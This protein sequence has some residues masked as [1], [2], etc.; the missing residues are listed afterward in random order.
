MLTIS[1]GASNATRDHTPSSSSSKTH[2]P[3]PRLSRR[4]RLLVVSVGSG[5]KVMQV[6]IAQPYDKQVGWNTTVYN[7]RVNKSLKEMHAMSDSNGYVVLSPADGSVS[8]ERTTPDIYSRHASMTS[9]ASR[10]KYLADPASFSKA[11]DIV[12][13]VQLLSA[14]NSLN[15]DVTVICGNL[16][17]SSKSVVFPQNPP[18]LQQAC[19]FCI[20][21]GEKR[22]PDPDLMK[23]PVKSRDDFHFFSSFK[24][25]S[26]DNLRAGVTYSDLKMPDGAADSALLEAARRQGQ[27]DAPRL[28]AR[29]HEVPKGWS[30]R[31][32]AKYGDMFPP[33]IMSK[34]ADTPGYYIMAK[35]ICR[36]LR[37]TLQ[38][39][40]PLQA[41]AQRRGE[42][43]RHAAPHE[44][45]PLDGRGVPCRSGRCA[46]L[47]PRRAW[48]TRDRK[49]RL[50]TLAI[51]ARDQDGPRDGR[52]ASCDRSTRRASS[53]RVSCVRSIARR[54]SSTQ[55]R[56]GGGVISGRN[57]LSAA[58]FAY[59]NKYHVLLS[60]THFSRT[61]GSR[62]RQGGA[63][64]CFALWAPIAPGGSGGLCLM[65][66]DMISYY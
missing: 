61:L 25:F 22:Q 11:G 3:L 35:D 37:G 40:P 8:I 12:H 30:M 59:L 45:A 43:L 9:A 16:I 24:R 44:P 31:S 56:G 26:A 6:Q 63:G 14:H 47:P 54:A 17:G 20:F 51:G 38:C 48:M 66:F 5:E 21:S 64:P 49:P 10:S 2:A 23:N 58:T 53:T 41:S 42:S 60:I 33:E 39:R 57:Y 28:V 34:S 36:S 4:R 50:A 62:Q 29:P 46:S 15:A 27:R 52:Q 18:D 13:E 65:R 32:Y 1:V 19:T 55:S 7:I